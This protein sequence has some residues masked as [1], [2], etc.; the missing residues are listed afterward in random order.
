MLWHL[1]LAS[2]ILFPSEYLGPDGNSKPF[3]IGRGDN[4]EVF[5]ITTSKGESRA[6]KYN[7]CEN[8]CRN[9]PVDE[10]GGKRICKECK[11]LEKEFNWLHH[12]RNNP[13]VISVYDKRYF[14]SI[15]LKNPSLYCGYVMEYC[16]SLNYNIGHFKLLD[17]RKMAK[18]MVKGLILL[19]RQGY[20][21]GDLRIDNIV[22]CRDS[23][24]YKMIDPTGGIATVGNAQLKSDVI[25]LAQQLF[26]AYVPVYNS[27]YDPHTEWS[28]SEEYYSEKLAKIR[29]ALSSVGL[30]DDE[31]NKKYNILWLMHFRA[32][33]RNDDINLKLGEVLNHPFLTGIDP[34][35]PAYVWNTEKW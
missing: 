32:R 10:L 20:Y 18:D 6:L 16:S 5:G 11:G 29:K 34:E 8:E 2:A 24:S 25:S 4:G 35:I 13:Y 23:D 12:N 33:I 31:A 3:R 19:Q 30:L 21:H 9:C 27:Y 1:C 22:Y 14:E 26:L 7:Y 15:N 28:Q 17:I